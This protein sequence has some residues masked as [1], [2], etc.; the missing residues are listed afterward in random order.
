MGKLR[1]EPRQPGS[2]ACI[3]DHCSAMYRVIQDL[4]PGPSVLHTRSQVFLYPLSILLMKQWD[5]ATTSFLALG[6]FSQ[7][8]S[9]PALLSNPCGDQ[10]SRP[11]LNQPVNQMK[12]FESPSAQCRQETPLPLLYSLCPSPNSPFTLSIKLEAPPGCQDPRKP[13]E[14]SSVVGKGCR[15]QGLAPKSGSIKTR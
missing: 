8:P 11:P 9:S 12:L 1:C 3:P 6:L 7:W 2:R 14:I 15:L 4:N 13:A 5:T 10:K